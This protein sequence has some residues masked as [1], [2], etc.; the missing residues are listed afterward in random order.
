MQ[1]FDP[2]YTSA[3]SEYLLENEE[4]WTGLS[5][6]LFSNGRFML[7]GRHEDV[8]LLTSGESV[9][10]LV[11]NSSEGYT[12]PALVWP[13]SKAIEESLA[14][15][16]QEL[17]VVTTIL[18][19]SRIVDLCMANCRQKPAYRV[20]YLLMARNCS[21]VEMTASP[22]GEEIFCADRSMARG[23]YPLQRE[24]E[25]EEV[26]LQPERFNPLICMTHLKETLNSQ[27]VFAAR[28]GRRFTAKAGTNARGVNWSQI[29][30]V[31]TLPELRG[32]GISRRL[33]Q[34]VLNSLYSARQGA[35]LFVKPENLPAVHLYQSLGFYQTS[36]FS[37]A[38]YLRE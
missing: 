13:F 24:Y 28:R 3:V 12:F 29:G 20:N 4:C 33:M 17:P 1:V 32:Q 22:S 7:P 19:D 27:I 38:Y 36:R 25:K 30:G 5:A 23:I 18:G 15:L 9:E 6:R 37:I 11:Y 16:L 31:Y 35:S 10:A 26:L 34:R 21:S 14:V 2:F 8:R